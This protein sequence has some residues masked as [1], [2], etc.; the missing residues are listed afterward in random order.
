M[1]NVNKNNTELNTQATS[2]Y[3]GQWETDKIIESYFKNKSDGICIEV[4]AANGYK[5]SNTKYF[6]DIGWDALCIEP[7]IEHKE[8]LT[9][10]RKFVRYYAC[11]KENKELPLHI[12]RVGKDDI[13]SSLTSLSPDERLVEDHKEIINDSYKVDVKVRTLNW[14]LENETSDTPFENVVDID[15]ISIDTEGTELDVI[16][17]LDFDKYSVKLLIIENNYN[18]DNIEE[19]MNL[20][21]YKKDKRYK[22]NDFY[23]K[24]EENKI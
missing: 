2:K 14:I 5:G 23:I 17:G 3:Y 7:N 9:A 6:E 4:G 8:S 20:M 18:D 11:G 24:P 15:F 13:T 10:H 21:G 19:Y 12:F 1:Y 16:K 22:I